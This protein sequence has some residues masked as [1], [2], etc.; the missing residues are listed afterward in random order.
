MR[1]RNNNT[2]HR[3][4]KPSLASILWSY[5]RATND[6]V[7]SIQLLVSNLHLTSITQH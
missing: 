6:S 5:S 4:I 7:L 2:P 3:D 1:E